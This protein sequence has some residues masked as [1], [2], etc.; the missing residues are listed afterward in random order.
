MDVICV[1][2]SNTF[3]W[4]GGFRRDT[5]VMAPGDPDLPDLPWS[6]EYARTVFRGD[7]VKGKKG[8]GGL[9]PFYCLSVLKRVD[10]VPVAVASFQKIGHVVGVEFLDAELRTELKYVFSDHAQELTL[11]PDGVQRPGDLFL[12]SATGVGYGEGKNRYGNPVT[13]RQIHRLNSNTGLSRVHA[14]LDYPDRPYSGPAE[15]QLDVSGD[16]FWE[17]VATFGD[18]ERWFVKDRP[19][20]KLFD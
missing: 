2:G 17:P 8:Y 18:W 14:A 16:G 11:S 1:P 12:K 19:G 9:P 10:G 4:G 3:H 6:E 13:A 7:H 5:G 15:E 20:V